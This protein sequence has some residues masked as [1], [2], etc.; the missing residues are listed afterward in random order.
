MN[1]TKQRNALNSGTKEQI[2]FSRQLISFHVHEFKEGA[3]Y[4][5]VRVLFFYYYSNGMTHSEHISKRYTGT[6]PA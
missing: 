5:S 3:M 2:Q 6:L 4:L 1:F